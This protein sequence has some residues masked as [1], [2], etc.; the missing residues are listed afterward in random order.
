MQTE[1][2]YHYLKNHS[3][4]A[5]LNEEQVKDL[6]NATK[7]KMADKG[8]TIFF[9]E[10]EEQKIYFL[11]KGKIKI[12]EVDEFG[13]EL[14]KEIIN[15]GDFFGEVSL[16]GGKPNDEY[17]QALT[18]DTVLC[19]FTIPH[20]QHIMQNN[21][22]LALNYVQKVGVKLRR[23][24][25]RHS[26]LVFKDVK[27]RLISFFKD[28]AKREGSREGNKMVL[29]NYLTHNDIANLISTSR[30]SVTGLLNELKEMGFLN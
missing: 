16:D 3:L 23:L 6:C 19:S 30:Q 28:W 11:L 20:F 10:S 13:N 12:T 5:N 14:I 24:E 25:N 26:D 27:A 8:E 17:A 9:H 21:S 15:E 4:S 29:K 18:D 1:V 22:V 2:K 7:L